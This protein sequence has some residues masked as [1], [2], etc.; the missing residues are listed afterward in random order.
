MRGTEKHKNLSGICTEG[1]GSTCSA[2]FLKRFPSSF[3]IHTVKHEETTGAYLK[4]F[5]HKNAGNKDDIVMTRLDEYYIDPELRTISMYGCTTMDALAIPTAI[6][7]GCNEIYMIGTDKSRSHFYDS[8]P[9]RRH[10]EFTHVL[11]A[12]KELGVKL[13]NADPRNAFSEVE[14]KKY[15][16]LFKG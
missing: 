5:K 8:K 12:L 7:L 16:D 3:K 2:R 15:E 11:P 13:Y 4:F 14:Y 9:G 10:I 1:P 6:Y